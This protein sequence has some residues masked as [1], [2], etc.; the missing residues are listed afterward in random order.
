MR[1]L[2]ALVIVVTG[3]IVLAAAVMGGLWP[4]WA[5]L[6]PL[7]CLA[8]LA[9]Q[10]AIGGYRWQMIPAY[11]VIAAF[12]LSGVYRYARFPRQGRSARKRRVPWLVL[13]IAGFLLLLTSVAAGIA[14]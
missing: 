1:L 4:R 11:L 12:C 14:T 5:N 9:A 13:G 8:P 2:E 3:Q 7:A 10:L 6:L